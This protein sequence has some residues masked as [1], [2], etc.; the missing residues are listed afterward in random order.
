MKRR[1]L[2]QQ[3]LAVR[4]TDWRDEQ[5]IAASVPFA[6]IGGLGDVGVHLGIDLLLRVCERAQKFLAVILHNWVIVALRFGALG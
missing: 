5:I 2:S 6:D 3:F 1:A 4:W